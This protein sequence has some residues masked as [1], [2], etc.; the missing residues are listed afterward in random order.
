[1]VCWFREMCTNLQRVPYILGEEK[2]VLMCWHSPRDN[3]KGLFSMCSLRSLSIQ[4]FRTSKSLWLVDSDFGPLGNIVGHRTIEES[5]EWLWC[6]RGFWA[7]FYWYECIF[8]KQ[9]F[10]LPS[11]LALLQTNVFKY[12]HGPRIKLYG[13]QQRFG[14]LGTD[15]PY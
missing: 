8:W 6:Q 11:H 13:H 3:R 7:G 2:F 14:K 9:L 15:S 5:M 1:M 10:L 12:H 4:F